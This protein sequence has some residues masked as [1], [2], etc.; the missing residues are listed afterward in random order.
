MIAVSDTSPICYLILIGEIDILPKLYAQV[1]VPP[2]VIAEGD[3]GPIWQAIGT[4]CMLVCSSESGS[5]EGQTNATNPLQK[6]RPNRAGVR[7]HQLWF[8]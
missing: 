3:L 5:S 7:R 1:L 2:A 6:L 4:T 8:R